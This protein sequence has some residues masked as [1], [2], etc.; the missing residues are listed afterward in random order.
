VSDGSSTAGEEL[1]LS[2]ELQV[3]EVY[4][5]FRDA[6]RQGGPGPWP[7]I[8]DYVDGVPG[9]VRAR[10]LAELI[11]VERDAR[12][13]A[14]ED[15]HPGEYQERFPEL[16][17]E[18]L[19]RVFA[20]RGAAPPD[21]ATGPEVNPPAEVLMPERLGRY[22]LLARLGV[23]SFGVV[24]KAH[25]E[26]LNR[27]VAVKVAHHDRVSAARDVQ[28]YL[29]EARVLAGL[30]HPG[31]VP[32]YDVGRTEDGLCYLVEQFV[33]GGD[34]A[35][36]LGQGRPTPAE[37]V[38]IVTRVAEA[39]HHAHERGLVHRD[40]KPGNILFEADGRPVLADFGLALRE[41]DFGHGPAFAGTPV[42]MSPEQARGE[43]HRVDA[44]TD[45]Y[46]L[47]VVFYELLTGCWP[48]RGL[49]AADTADQVDVILDQIKTQEPRPPRQLDATLPQE[50]ER[51]CLKALAKRVPERYSTALD[52]A[53]DLRHW[54][55]GQGPAPADPD[56]QPLQVLPRGLRAFDIQDAPFFLELLPG[57]RDRDGLPD[58][59]RFWKTRVEETDPDGTFP[60]GLLYGP[61]GCGKSSL[62]KAGL[63][64]RLARHVIA[65]YVEATPEDTEARLLKTLRKR[66]PGLPPERGL[67]E[68]LACLR[69]G[70]GVPAGHKVLIVLDQFEQWLHAHRD[71]ANA[72]LVQALRHS[73]GEHV[74]CLVLVR[75]DFWMAATRFFRELEVRLAEGGNS[76]AVDL[77]DKQH[78]RKVLA[79]FGRAFRALPEGELSSGAEMFL[80]QAVEELARDGK[81][82]P[83]RL[84]LF[85]EMVKGRTWTPAALK[86]VGGLEGLGV[87]FLEETFSAGTAPPAHRLHQHAARGVLKA[88][89]PGHGADIKGQMHSHEELLAASGYAGRPADFEGLLQILD[90]EL[91]L[92]TPSESEAAA[93]GV[94]YYQLTHDYLVPALRQWLTREQQ[95]TRRGRAE[96]RL[97]ERA[98][99]WQDRPEPRHL[100]SWWEWAS[101]GLLT[102]SRD[103]T[104]AQRQM[105][106]LATGHHSLRAGL[107]GV[108]LVLAVCGIWAALTFARASALVEQLVAPETKTDQM[109]GIVET[110][111]AH[112]VW[113]SL[114]LRRSA[115]SR[116]E[117]ST[118]EL[119]RASLGLALLAP[120]Q[121]TDAQVKA[122]S[123]WYLGAADAD[124]LKVAAAL[125]PALR[126][127]KE[128][129]TQT[130]AAELGRPW[131]E[132]GDAPDLAAGRRGNAAIA[133]LQFGSGESVWA[134]MQ[135]EAPTLRTY[136]IHRLGP[137][138]TDPQL[139]LDRYHANPGV[140]ERRALILALGEYTEKEL[141]ADV[142]AP[143][144]EQLLQ[145]Y[146]R[147]PD[148]GIH[149]AIDWL[150]RPGK[151]GAAP[152][153]LDWGQAGVLGQ[154]DTELQ[155]QRPD[156]TRGW[157]VNGQGQTMM[158]V[159]GPVEFGMGSPREERE[160]FPDAEPL[161]HV[162][163]GRSYAI[164]SKEV[165]VAQFRKFRG[166][167][168]PEEDR[169]VRKFS[170]D[171][172]GPVLAVTWYEAARYCN[173][174]SRQEGILPD[175]WCYVEKRGED[176]ESVLE[177]SENYLSRTGY[178]LP[179][180]AEWEFAC[181]ARTS[182]SRSYGNGTGMLG[183][184][185]WYAANSQNR[186][187]PVG[188]LKPND[189]G[190][191]DMYGNAW[192]WCQDL[193][194]AGPP[195]P[196]D[197][198]DMTPLSVLQDRV[199]RGG[200]FDYHAFRA[201]SAASS[202]A[203]ATSREDLVGFRVARS[204][205]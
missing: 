123:A 150:L 96:L 176:G 139:L 135:G 10:L 141:A 187:W 181:R 153:K 111:R 175:Q 67:V 89:L 159:P 37:A 137:L 79:A 99:L 102:R 72:E 160:V 93:P 95:E 131:R 80:D 33:A 4:R 136:L 1:P 60:V 22:R 81:V 116:N 65:H 59:I 162:C 132:N 16:D 177:M 130:V 19:A 47:G 165:T 61:S 161:H 152:R 140:S 144:V 156:G 106:R 134:G 76:A 193:K 29:A 97:A 49:G 69:R 55:A 201:R 118:P 125:L 194:R 148:P 71:A 189:Y 197:V 53:E 45:V 44:R 41:E 92:V 203:Q 146:R 101:I 21:G 66:C 48:F 184:Y 114:L 164:A 115:A 3:D 9:T 186:S 68:T 36:R 190:L 191:F 25:D 91:R 122:L 75:D 56:K 169:I 88:L 83:V 64:P 121:L 124:E 188:L 13:Q 11:L 112:R 109:L 34:L 100:P 85:A 26:E 126:Q 31:I 117:D 94:K 63:L 73:D 143:L 205:P 195:A 142:R 108:V 145:W 200:S 78:A 171:E 151:E 12:R 182:T 199:L 170:P 138:R 24:F 104:A 2:V 119:P 173:W 40:V 166:A 196:E 14:H 113:A 178:R 35:A 51:I 90:S 70:H 127:H 58:S 157:Y 8:E 15:P 128:A 28:A 30:N 7:R 149:G 105:M 183:R 23:G 202:Y 17:G 174:L 77:F 204:C 82:I 168:D 167:R 39:L 54:Q 27:V 103:W 98:A 50:L 74:Q 129:A 185:A 158:V 110:L 46:S 86:G 107:V 32:V 179:T 38:E 147:D 42:Y 6:V 57:P 198:E 62:V 20:E 87:R 192:E 52:L 18:W 172:E 84:S 154:I 43:G 120:E 5:R 155:R 133:L 163:I 180:A